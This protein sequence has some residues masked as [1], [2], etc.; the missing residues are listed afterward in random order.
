MPGFGYE[1]EE[2]KRISMKDLGIQQRRRNGCMLVNNESQT[3]FLWCM[4][5]AGVRVCR[6]MYLFIYKS[7]Q[8]KGSLGL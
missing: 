3:G 2:K 5:Y 6:G 8:H 7:V 4:V 1:W